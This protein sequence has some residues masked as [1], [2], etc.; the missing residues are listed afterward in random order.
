M[1]VQG[2]ISASIQLE[3]GRKLPGKLQKLST[4]GGLLELPRY[5]E[6]RVWVSLTIQLSSGVVHPTA[7]MM[8]PMRASKGYLQPFRITRIWV[9][10][11]GIL[12]AEI[13]ALLRQAT[14]GH[15]LGVRPPGFL[16]ESF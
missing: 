15:R 7:E 4:T 3:N 14:V 6:E 11:K 16:L 2:T 10:E 12:E 8:F 1:N 9:E 5:V 13:T